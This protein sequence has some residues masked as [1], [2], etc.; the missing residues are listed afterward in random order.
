MAVLEAVD[1]DLECVDHLPYGHILI[2]CKEFVSDAFRDHLC[3]TALIFCNDS[4][5]LPLCLLYHPKVIAAACIYSAMHFRKQRSM[6]VGVDQ[7]ISGHMWFKWIDSAIEAADIMEVMN[8]M[9]TLYRAAPA[10]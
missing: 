4:F 3:S 10:L 7:K 9:K 6:E 5:K 2:F 1:F 8:H